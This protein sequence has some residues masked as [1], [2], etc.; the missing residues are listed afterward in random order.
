MIRIY[1]KYAIL[2]NPDPPT[3]AVSKTARETHQKSKGFLG[4]RL[5]AGG[6]NVRFWGGKTYHRVP[7]PKPVLEAS[8]SWIRLVCACCL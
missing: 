3:L 7:P 6:G 1:C 4:K 5:V 8:E 2:R